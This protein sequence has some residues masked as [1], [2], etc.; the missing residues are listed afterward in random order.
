MTGFNVTKFSATGFNVTRLSWLLGIVLILFSGC[1]GNFIGSKQ[2]GKSSTFSFLNTYESALSDYNKGR[3]MIARERILAMDKTRKDYPKAVKLLKQKVEPARLRLLRHYTRKAKAADQ[4]GKWSHAM[5]YYEQAAELNTTPKALNRK[6]QSMQLKM[7]Q[8][9]MDSLITQ[10]RAEDSALLSWP[11]SYEPPKGVSPKDM[12]FERAREFS[13]DMIEDRGS[14]AYREARRYLGKQHPEIAYIEA[15]SY[16]RLMPNSDRGKRLMESVKKEMPKGIR[17]APVKALSTK[18]GKLSKRS[19]LPDAVTRDQVV[20]LVRK[21]NLIRAK[22][23]A[24]IYRRGGGKD[25]ERLLKQIQGSIKKEA[26]KLFANGRVAFRKENLERAIEF[27]E[28]AVA[29]APEHDEYVDAL[30]RARQLQERLRVLR[31]TTEK[32]KAQ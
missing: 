1:T 5:V 20:E 4:A 10:R 15:E 32:E 16:L 6:A 23:Y 17:I 31:N 25:S 21:G 14:L 9:R 28:K 26:V 11:E 24:L 13:Q 30:R 29:L 8:A 19:T 27:W 18:G 22:K 3:I 12:I 7:R 2:A